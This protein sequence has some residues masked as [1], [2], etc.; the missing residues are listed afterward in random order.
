MS[1]LQVNG[2]ILKTRELSVET[3]GAL[4]LLTDVET[5]D[6]VPS[7]LT[8]GVVKRAIE[9][10]PKNA[11]RSRLKTTTVVSQPD[12]VSYRLDEHGE[13]VT[14][15]KSRVN[16]T[17]TTPSGGA[18]VASDAVETRD[19]VNGQRTRE[20][21][22]EVFP[23]TLYAIR[24][25]DLV[26]PAFRSLL[27]V[28]TTAVTESGTAVP[29]APGPELVESSEEQ[30]T[31][32]IKRV[33]NSVL[34]ATSGVLTDYLMVEGILATRTRD[35]EPTL[36]T[37]T[38]NYLV[39]ESEVD[40]LGNGAS[41]KTEIA[42]PAWPSLVGQKFDRTLGVGVTFSQQ[43]TSVADAAGQL[44]NDDTDITPKDALRSEV[45]ISDVDAAVLDAYMRMYAS[46]IPRIDFPAILTSVSVTWETTQGIGDSAEQGATTITGGGNLYLNLPDSSQASAT[47]IPD[48]VPIIQDVYA[49]NIPAT[50]YV[51]FVVD[52]TATSAVLARIPASPW[53]LFRPVS[54]VFTCKGEKVSVRA[55]ANTQLSIH[56]GTS[57]FSESVSQGD[58]GEQ[59]FSSVVRSV[60]T[61]PVIHGT[62]TLTGDTTKT[63][64]V[65]ANAASTI[66]GFAAA[67]RNISLTAKGAVTPGTLGATP[68]ISAV[69]TSGLYAYRVTTE[70]YQSGYT[71]VRVLV[72]DFADL[73]IS[74]GGEP[75]G[76]AP[77]DNTPTTELGYGTDSGSSSGSLLI[78]DGESAKNSI[79]PKVI[80]A[81]ISQAV[82][83]GDF[84]TVSAG[85]SGTAPLTFQWQ[86]DGSDISGATDSVYL[87]ASASSGDAGVYTLIVTNDLGMDTSSG[88]TLVVDSVADPV[89]TVQPRTQITP[90]GTAVTLV[91]VASGTPSFA[92]QWYRNSALQPGAT[93]ASYTT[94]GAGTYYVIVTGGLGSVTS[95]DAIV[96]FPGVG[97]TKIDFVFPAN[98]QITTGNLPHPVTAFTLAGFT[99]KLDLPITT[100]TEFTITTTGGGSL[101]NELAGA[102]F[103]TNKI[104]I[105]GGGTQAYTNNLFLYTGV[106]D[107]VTHHISEPKKIYFTATGAGVSTTIN[108]V[109]YFGEG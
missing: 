17:I 52:N 66:P 26:P 68:G 47:V 34:A 67:T 89:I 48:V 88:G 77:E 80:I 1:V 15:T 69:P 14:V 73:A 42:V 108:T 45:V 49:E 56:L 13:L 87:I 33:E 62:I 31:K 38:P 107:D 24:Y 39:T 11:N 79:A 60:T 75:I 9:Q 76:Y 99:L 96:S 109:F 2:P 3:E 44:G 71:L 61:K 27:G 28:L 72:V 40:A 64:T 10:D 23:N 30:L 84:V 95:D 98:G 35:Y 94:F 58:G 21:V 8:Y 54:H 90:M 57:D 36:Q 41:L 19:G 85:I 101:S 92:Y 6:Q 74:G 32:Y 103:H 16:P 29:P 50:E 86:K 78:A 51:F 81:P 93:S 70:G 63:A 97:P 83:T 65:L 106:A 25:P 43:V 18:L 46:T 100:D 105:V 102:Q 5:N 4:L 91:V 22:P 20:T 59:D 53:P 82:S 12:R 104:L 7:A 55:S 37:I